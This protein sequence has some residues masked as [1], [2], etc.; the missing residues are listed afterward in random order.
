M[1][2]RFSRRTFFRG[3]AVVLAGALV[4]PVF[5][6]CTRS[7]QAEP[8][9]FDSDP[10]PLPIPP[11]YEGELVDGRRHFQV[12]TQAGAAEILPGVTTATWGFSGDHLGPTFRARR[13]DEIRVDITNELDEM[14]TIH[15]HGMKLPAWADGGPHSPIEPGSTWTPEWTVNQPAATLWYH[16]HPHERTALHCYRGLAGMFILEDEVSEGLDLPSEYGVDDIPVIIAD[17]KF[18]DDG[19]LDEEIDPT[20]G[21][22]GDTPLVNGI[23]N[24]R[25]DASTRRVRLRLLNAAGMRFHHL[26]LSDA[27]SFHVISSDSG[28]LAA[29]EEVDSVLLG[30]AERVDIIV[31]L[32]PGEEVS[33]ESVG[34]DNNF[35]IPTGENS[36]DF[37]FGDTFTLLRLTGPG[38][39]APPPAGLPAEL[40]P[41]AS[42]SP[43]LAGAPRRDFVLNTFEI[44]GQLMDMNRVDFVIDHKG[45]EV[46]TVSN[47]NADWPHN[48]HVHDARFKVLGI[49][50]TDVTEVTTS[51]WKDTVALPPQAT[52][53]LLVEFGWYPDN[54]VPYMFHCHM[55]MHEDMGMMGQFMV[56]APGQEADLVPM[57]GHRH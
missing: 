11:L 40:D 5:A 25:F 6:A 52:A 42:A 3:A 20:F 47:E 8:R 31:D 44:N 34:L 37:G 43:D 14:T 15:W 39:E 53:E 56:V 54:T 24:C 22:L 55:L 57:S 23:T 27:R 2:S 30:P 45:P 10:R 26:A 35:G 46:W 9:G 17:A 19:Q 13:G 51:G 29:P 18:H 38:E 7:D 28:L 49:S 36:P 50:G 16:P 21:L 41:V 1:T 48:F 4:T 12:S 32:E 33:L